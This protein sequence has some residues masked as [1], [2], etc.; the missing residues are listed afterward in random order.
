MRKYEIEIKWG[1]IFIVATLIWMG[2][3]NVVGLH[4]VHI[5]KH[6]Y[7]TNLF[8][9]VAIILY[10]L[11]LLDK[12]RNFYNNRM[13]WKQGFISGLIITLII[14]AFSPLTQLIV[15]KIIAP[16]YFTNAIEYGA[17]LGKDPE[18]L[19]GYFNLRSYIVQ[20][21]FGTFSLGMVTSA[22][23]ALFVRRS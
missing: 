5:D 11:A 12:R 22:V 10:V 13:S 8:G 7:Y 15:H 17:S 1:L 23:V 14:A 3:E 19:A 4:T 21:L 9:I 16:S 20:S 2:I 6:M 18:T